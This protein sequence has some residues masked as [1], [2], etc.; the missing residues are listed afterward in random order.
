M[1][2]VKRVARRFL[3]GWLFASGIVALLATVFS[4]V[5]AGFAA[6]GAL[7]GECSW[8]MP[9]GMLAIAMFGAAVMYTIVESL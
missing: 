5:V 8:W 1:N 4:I 6:M 3:K 9:V 2:R 7:S